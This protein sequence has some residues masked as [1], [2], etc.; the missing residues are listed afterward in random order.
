MP[1]KA[2]RGQ[3]K[4]SQAGQLESL[5]RPFSEEERDLCK[6]CSLMGKGQGLVPGLR[7]LCLTSAPYKDRSI[8]TMMFRVPVSARA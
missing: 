2:T 1:D 3:S 6:N 7:I 4:P 8:S 5:L